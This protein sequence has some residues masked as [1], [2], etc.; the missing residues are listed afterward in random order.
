MR[1]PVCKAD[2]N[3]AL[4]CRR[5]KADLSLLVAVERRRARVMA[6]A[7]TRL[8]GDPGGALTAAGEGDRLRRDE[9]SRRLLAVARLVNRDFAGALALRQEQT[10]APRE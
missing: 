3:E 10:A 1:C 8:T 7:V 4:Q 9:E 5:C 6:D 2:N